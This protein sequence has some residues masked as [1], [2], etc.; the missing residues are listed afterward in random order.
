MMMMML[1]IMMIGLFVQFDIINLHVMVL[2][3]FGFPENRRREG[4][5]FL[6]GISDNTVTCVHC[7]GTVFG[8]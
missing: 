7:N 4:R 6:R 8:K 3:V 2:R 5:T 1:M